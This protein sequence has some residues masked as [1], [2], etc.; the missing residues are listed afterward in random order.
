MQQNTAYAKIAMSL[1]A[2]TDSTGILQERIPLSSLSKQTEKKG[3][4]KTQLYTKDVF[5][6]FYDNLFL[7]WRNVLWLTM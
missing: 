3:Q 2:N 5:A 4:V 6:L 1:S 7:L